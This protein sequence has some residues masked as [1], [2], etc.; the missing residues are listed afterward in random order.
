MRLLFNRRSWSVLACCALSGCASFDRPFAQQPPKLSA[1]DSKHDRLIEDAHQRAKSGDLEG[2]KLILNRIDSSENY[3]GRSNTRQSSD[4]N[5]EI[6]QVGHQTRP[7]AGT[8]QTLDQILDE[9]VALEAAPNRAARRAQ[10]EALSPT[11]LRQIHRESKRAEEMGQLQLGK[12]EANAPAREQ[13]AR[14]VTR[15]TA[16]GPVPFSAPDPRQNGQSLAGRASLDAPNTE[17]LGGVQTPSPAVPFPSS[18]IPAAASAGHFALGQTASGYGSG[19]SLTGI[20]PNTNAGISQTAAEQPQLANSL[21]TITPARPG[22]TASLPMISAAK[23]GSSV[24]APSSVAGTSSGIAPAGG[25]EPDP[26]TGRRQTV[27]PAN[28]TISAPTLSPP[29]QNSLT[30]SPNPSPTPAPH[31]L[32]LGPLSPDPL[33]NRPAV[34]PA[35]LPRSRFPNTLT[36]PVQ[37]TIQSLRNAAERLPGVRSFAPTG[38]PLP[39]AAAMAAAPAPSA[40]VQLLIS[41]LEAQLATG[42]PGATEAERVDYLRKH[43][44]LRLLYLIADRNDQ[45]LEPIRGIDPNEQEFWQQM[46]WSIAAYFDV[47]GQP[48]A[49]DRATQTVAQLRTAIHQLKSQAELELRNVTFCQRIDSYGNFERLSRDQFSP[50]IPVLLYAEIDNFRSVPADGDRHMTAIKST[51]EFYKARGDGKLI[52]SIPFDVSQ[53]YCR[54]RRRD[55]FLA[56]EFTVPQQL[57]PG[58]YTLVLKVEDQLGQKATT[59]KVNFTVE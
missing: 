4:S 11:S 37:N 35:D 27:S 44:N 7:A 1:R 16:N 34:P 56:Y 22:Q 47:Q 55:Y 49:S 18:V 5:S 50:G 39:L 45:A 29:I 6:E 12:F 41:Q 38:E 54:N 48:R 3:A 24:N 43:V 59:A 13:A 23:S 21:P 51:V 9:L 20:Q 40:E 14:A 33:P 30:P 15:P 19:V 31:T 17:P 46:I 25:Q 53:D 58:T 42:A 8:A 2:A 52:Q 28:S 57:E 36:N 26:R 32:G 10:L